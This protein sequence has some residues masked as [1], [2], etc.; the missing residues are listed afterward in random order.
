[1]AEQQAAVRFFTSAEYEHELGI[2]KIPDFDVQRFDTLGIGI[3]DEWAHPSS[4]ARGTMRANLDATSRRSSTL[5]SIGFITSRS[6]LPTLDNNAYGIGSNGFGGPGYELGHGRALSSLGYELHGYRAST[7]GESFQDIIRQYINRFI[8][9]ASLNYR[10][11]S[12]L[13][14]RLEPGVDFTDAPISNS[15]RAVRARM[16]ARV[17][18]AP[19]TTI[20]RTSVRRR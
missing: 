4:L 10:P 1:M 16:S 17:A 14:A 13:S 9:S 2:F 7:P 11:T 3:K 12:W 6:Q 5:P 18:R 19:T 15:A 8:G 20:A